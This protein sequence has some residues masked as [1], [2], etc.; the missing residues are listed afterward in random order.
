VSRPAL[1][2]TNPHL[3]FARALTLFHPPAAPTPG[4]H[5][6]AVVA[7][8]A[9]VAPTACVGPLCVIGPRASIGPGSWLEAQV[10]VGTGVRVGAECRVHAQVSLRE[11]TLVGD[12]VI[13][14][15]GAVLGADGFG[16]ARDGAR[17]VKIPQVGRVVVEDE[18]EI[19]ANT[20]IDRAT[21]GETR[22]G[23][24]T[25]IDNLVQVAHN[26][27][28]GPDAVIVAAGSARVG[29]RAVLAG[30]VGVVDHVGI[31]DDAV[32]GAQSGVKRD[33]PDR[34]IVLGSPAVP[35]TD[36]KRQLAAVATLPD[37]RKKVRDLEARLRALEA[38]R[39]G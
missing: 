20:T 37:L 38:G 35:H 8:D 32:V 34:A 5:P 27:V 21:L 1:R 2:S 36:A 17:R 11:G 39:A 30:Q 13:L 28:I 15:S 33:V 19:G 23:R 10:F 3:A 4:I 9:T 7:R 24:G 16:Y 6:S 25:K 22:V 29:A 26:V 31:G 18:V 12:R 14:H